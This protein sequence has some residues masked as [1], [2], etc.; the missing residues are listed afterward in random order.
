MS[1]ESLVSLT[2]LKIFLQINELHKLHY[3]HG[4]LIWGVFG[5]LSPCQ[6]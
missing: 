6:K 1:F 3:K 2:L 4:S 5:P